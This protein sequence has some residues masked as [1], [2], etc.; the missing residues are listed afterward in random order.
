MPLLDSGGF[1]RRTRAGKLIK[2]CL[3]C[4]LLGAGLTMMTSGR[5][6]VHES[7]S[8]GSA[9]RVR[10]RPGVLFAAGIAMVESFPV[11]I[12]ADAGR[13]AGHRGLASGLVTRRDRSSVGLR[14]PAF[15]DHIAAT[16]LTSI[17]IGMDAVPYR[18]PTLPWL[19][20]YDMI[21]APALNN[22]P[23]RRS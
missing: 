11:S 22:L 14:A 6:S 4:G 1:V 20:S 21:G 9:N 5:C 16:T 3:A 18:S 12:A 15:H 23:W 7:A 17:R 2:S 19:G 10:D 13:Q 8:I